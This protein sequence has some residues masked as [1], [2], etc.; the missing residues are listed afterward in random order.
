MRRP[1]ALCEISAFGFGNDQTSNK[2]SVWIIEFVTIAD[3]KSSI[4]LKMREVDAK[5]DGMFL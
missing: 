1:F 4:G 2:D 3:A 5:H